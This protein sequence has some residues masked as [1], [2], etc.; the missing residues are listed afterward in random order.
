M[1]RSIPNFFQILFLANIDLIR[2]SAQTEQNRVAWETP[3]SE[4]FVP[5]QE[6]VGVLVS[7]VPHA[8]MQ[9]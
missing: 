8:Q 2:C 5:L 4:A 1:V 3:S 9:V 6:P 7:Y